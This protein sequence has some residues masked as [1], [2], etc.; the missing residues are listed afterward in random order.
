[1]SFQQD[2]QQLE[3]IYD[4]ASKSLTTNKNKI[5][6]VITHGA[7]FDGFMS[8]NNCKKVVKNYIVA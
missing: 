8:Q 5:D 3:T 7:C 1:M 6:F 2:Y 4:Y